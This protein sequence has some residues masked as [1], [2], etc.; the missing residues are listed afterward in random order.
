MG[1]WWGGGGGG[2][3]LNDLIV[4]HKVVR[5][6]APCHWWVWIEQDRGGGR[7]QKETDICMYSTSHTLC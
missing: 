5:V 2:I 3:R 6:C 7:G 1:G 4:I